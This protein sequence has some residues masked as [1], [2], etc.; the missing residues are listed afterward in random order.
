[1][2]K[3]AA[4]REKKGLYRLSLEKKAAVL[5]RPLLDTILSTVKVFLIFDEWQ[6]LNTPLKALSRIC[7]V[8]MPDQGC[9]HNAVLAIII[10]DQSTI[11]P[12][13]LG[14]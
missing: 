11:A 13:R 2:K 10:L 14:K 12:K 1:M 8:C 5:P 9:G 3:K 4:H 6:I 7:S